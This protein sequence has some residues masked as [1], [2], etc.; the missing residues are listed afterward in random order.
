MIE[1][2]HGLPDA[3]RKLVAAG[4][5]ILVTGIIFGVWILSLH[6]TS[7]P[8]APGVGEPTENQKKYEEPSPF[9]T[10]KD[11]VTKL[12]KGAKG[13]VQYFRNETG[14]KLPAQ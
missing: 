12:F 13:Q 10:L 8:Q 4:I 11:N 2:L 7:A 1:K 6:A 3:H 9:E 14:I 5:T